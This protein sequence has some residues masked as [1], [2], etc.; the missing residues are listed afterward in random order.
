MHVFAFKYQFAIG[1]CDYW[2]NIAFRMLIIYNA[3]HHIIVV[4]EDVSFFIKILS[5]Y[6][7]FIVLDTK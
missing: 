5:Y 2:L 4:V 6:A 1:L 7:N 3:Y